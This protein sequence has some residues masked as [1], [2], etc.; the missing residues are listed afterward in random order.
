MYIVWVLMTRIENGDTC[1][2]SRWVTGDLSYH[3]N[4]AELDGAATGG[5]AAAAALHFPHK[6]AVLPCVYLLCQVIY[7]PS[8]P[9]AA[10][11]RE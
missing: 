6:P 1:A 11:M 7:L 8:S 4:Q 9:A 10:L 3:L 5:A 2:L